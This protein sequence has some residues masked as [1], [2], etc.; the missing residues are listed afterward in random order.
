MLIHER[1]K[2]IA[3]A[4]RRIAEV[5]AELHLTLCDLEDVLKILR[6]RTYVTTEIDASD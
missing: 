6:D 4:V 1:Q 2:K 3:N 5:S